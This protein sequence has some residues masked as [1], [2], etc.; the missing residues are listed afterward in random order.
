GTLI[1]RMFCRPETAETPDEIGR[2]VQLGRVG[3][4]HA[5]KWRI[6]MAALRDP[7]VSD[8]AVQDIRRALIGQYFD[9]D[10]LCR[11]TGWTRAEVDTLDVYEGSSAVYNFPTER[12]IAALLQ[13]WFT[14]VEVIRCGTYALAERCPIL[15][16]RN[17]LIPPRKTAGISPAVSR[18]EEDRV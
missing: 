1:A 5:L 12:I 11:T 10:Q 2:D 13:R 4:F 17:P 6:A 14:D 7:T 15:V 9:R 8:I 16:A 18:R 3:S